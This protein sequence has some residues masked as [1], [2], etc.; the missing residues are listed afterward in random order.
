MS[1]ARPIQGHWFDMNQNSKKATGEQLELLATVENVDLDDLLE[2]PLSQGD[3]VTRLRRQM[4]QVI[5]PDV[6]AKRQKWRQ[7]RQK[8]KNCRIC[9]KIGDS[10]QHHFVNR[11]ILKTLDGYERHWSSRLK[12]C[13]PVCIDCHRDLHSR[14]NGSHSIAEFLNDEEKQYAERAIMALFEQHPKLF[15]MMA[16]GDDSVYETRLIRDFIEGKF[17]VEEENL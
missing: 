14:A 13:I 12:N 3:V 11:W 9:G 4:G 6:L 17:T 5:P 16:R 8:A 1:R 2:E 15:L 7:E 10:T